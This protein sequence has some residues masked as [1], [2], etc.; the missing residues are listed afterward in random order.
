MLWPA[1]LLHSLLASVFVC[2][3]GVGAGHLLTGLPSTRILAI[4]T[5]VSNEGGSKDVQCRVL[6]SRKPQVRK[7]GS[8]TAGGAC[9]LFK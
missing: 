2:T 1:C 9:N 4:V 5:E 6:Y 3:V 8:A 7:T